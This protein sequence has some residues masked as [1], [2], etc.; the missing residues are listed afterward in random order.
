MQQYD[1]NVY[2]DG[3]FYTLTEAFEN[4]LLNNE[5]LLEV[6]EKYNTAFNEMFGDR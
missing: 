2:C 6:H 1:L 4:G 3:K 5:Q